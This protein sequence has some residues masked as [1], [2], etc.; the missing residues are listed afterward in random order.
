VAWNFRANSAQFDKETLFV[1]DSN[2]A[3]EVT[4]ITEEFRE[5]TTGGEPFAIASEREADDQADVAFQ[6]GN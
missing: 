1:G 6:G 2:D 5:Y 3:T 4:E